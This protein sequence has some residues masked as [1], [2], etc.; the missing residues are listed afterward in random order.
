MCERYKKNEV[1][2]LAAKAHFDVVVVIDNPP[3]L[4]DILEM[5]PNTPTFFETH[6]PNVSQLHKFYSEL[7]NPH[8]E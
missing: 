6:I 7:N 8:L 2:T 1:G 4:I 5:C 3:V